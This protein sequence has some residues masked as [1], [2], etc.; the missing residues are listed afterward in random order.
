MKKGTS[1]AV[2]K[3][4]HTLQTPETDIVYDVHGPLPTADGRCDWRAGD[5]VQ[6]RI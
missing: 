6:R 1:E 2:T 3:T 4:T 5:D